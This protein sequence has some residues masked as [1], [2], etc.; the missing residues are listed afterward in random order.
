MNASRIGVIM[1]TNHLMSFGGCKKRLSDHSGDTN[2]VWEG[3][4]E[5]QSTANILK[6]TMEY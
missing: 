2:S 4:L 3:V 1:S 6:G 5:D